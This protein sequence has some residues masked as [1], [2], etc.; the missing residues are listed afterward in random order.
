MKIDAIYLKKF[1]NDEETKIQLSPR[2]NLFLGNNGQGKTSLLEAVW[3]CINGQSYRTSVTK[4]LIKFGSDDARIEI[5]TSGDN[6]INEIKLVIEENKKKIFVNDKKIKNRTELKRILSAVILD[7][8][9][10]ENLEKSHRPRRIILDSI[11]S[12]I[13]LGFKKKLKLYNDEIRR[14]NEIL[15]STKDDEILDFID[16]RL[17]DL[18]YSLSEERHLWIDRMSK[19]AEKVLKK[20][21]SKISLK[22]RIDS[23]SLDIN[24][25][26][27]KLKTNRTKEKITRKC[28]TGSHKDKISFI[29]NK[30]DAFEFGSEGEKKSLS[31]ALK[32]SEI[33]LIKKIN[34][35]YPIILVD[36]IGSEFDKERFNFFYR[37]I[38]TL[39]TQCFITANNKSILEPYKNKQ[40]SVFSIINGDCKKIS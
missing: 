39:E 19:I 9:F 34:K 23:D 26:T 4:N 35:D 5:R 10:K 40:S 15:S 27:K 37:F 30:S 1:R 36:E 28:M 8:E 18:S 29:L 22:F 25:L 21:D 6:S 11:I 24:N 16:K 2:I 17:I 31:M 38:A 33:L 3:T 7:R 12:N 32:I 20:L 13:S 14:K